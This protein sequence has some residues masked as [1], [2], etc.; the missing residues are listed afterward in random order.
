MKYISMVAMDSKT[1]ANRLIFDPSSPKRIA[2][3]LLAMIFLLY[4]L[5]LTPVTIAW[6]FPMVGWLLYC[7]SA[8]AVF[9]TIDMVVMCRTAYY[10]AGK[11]ETR[12]LMIFRRY[13]RSTFA[14]DLIIVCVDWLT[15]FVNS[16][17]PETQANDNPEVIGA[18]LVRFS[19]ATRAVR[20]VSVTRVVRI[21]VYLEHL[22]DRLHGGSSTKYVGDMARLIV[23]ILWIN[24]VMSCTW[25]YIGRVTVGDTGTSWL[26]DP[27]RDENSPFYSDTLPLFQYTTAFHWAITQMTPGSMQV[28]RIVGQ[29][30]WH[31]FEITALYQRHPMYVLSRVYLNAGTCLTLSPRQGRVGE[32]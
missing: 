13:L 20:I 18:K 1:L 2:F 6:D 11:L 19:K 7:T 3:D 25:F 29:G 15:V 5:C 9:W 31:Y 4:D 30:L 32:Q 8:V 17:F 21:Q 16:I 10:H 26:N 23:I 14:L 12:P 24:H 22:G 28:R 27:I